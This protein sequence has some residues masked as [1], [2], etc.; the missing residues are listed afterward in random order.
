[1]EQ[2]IKD[3]ALLASCKPMR[4]TFLTNNEPAQSLQSLFIATREKSTHTFRFVGPVVKDLKSSGATLFY[5]LISEDNKHIIFQKA[6]P[7]YDKG[8]LWRA[9][10][11]SDLE[12]HFDCIDFTTRFCRAYFLIDNVLNDGDVE[13][14][15]FTSVSCARYSSAINGVVIDISD[16]EV[17]NPE[18]INTNHYP[19][20]YGGW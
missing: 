17:I 16:K 10:Y 4:T 8:D 9:A 6:E 20:T 7:D 12:V 11:K 18:E 5:V 13:D 15:D 2:A 19:W 1:M 3:R 14:G